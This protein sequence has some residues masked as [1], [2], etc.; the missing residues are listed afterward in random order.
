MRSTSLGFLQ[1]TSKS[2]FE[3]DKQHRS[4]VYW[5]SDPSTPTGDVRACVN[6]THHR[7]RPFKLYWSFALCQSWHA[8]ETIEQRQLNNATKGTVNQ[9]LPW[10]LFLAYWRRDFERVDFETSLSWFHNTISVRQ[11]NYIAKANN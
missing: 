10:I 9:T 6:V 8:E 5:R 3:T 1:A 4:T 2:T 7:I 11:N